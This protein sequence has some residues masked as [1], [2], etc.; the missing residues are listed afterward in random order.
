MARYPQDPEKIVDQMI[1]RGRPADEIAA[2]VNWKEHFVLAR[3]ETIAKADEAR[4]AAEA[5]GYLAGLRFSVANPGGETA[6]D[7]KRGNNRAMTQRY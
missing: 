2:A 5:D 3:M 7:W 1:R 4:S 6:D